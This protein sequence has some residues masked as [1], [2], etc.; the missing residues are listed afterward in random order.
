MTSAIGLHKLTSGDALPIDQFSSVHNM[1]PVCRIAIL[2][3]ESTGKS[4]LAEALTQSIADLTCAKART[5]IVHKVDDVLRSW[6]KREGRTPDSNEQVAIA[7]SQAQAVE[8][9]Q[10]NWLIADTTSLMT[11]VYSHLLFGDT[12][13]YPIALAH[14]AIYTHTLITGLDLPWVAD[15][16]QRYGPQTRDPVDALLRQALDTA[17]LPYRVV[18]G[19]GAQ[20]LNNA[21]MAVGLPSVSP[22]TYTAREKTQFGLNQERQA[23]QCNGCSDPDCEQKLFTDLLRERKKQ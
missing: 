15:G 18:Y 4:W 3:A 7:Q 23:W 9:A 10:A 1:A 13:L 16:L 12:G 11:A 19:Q 6:C 5:P 22:E 14:H 17:H 20:R 2:G 8:Q 21:L